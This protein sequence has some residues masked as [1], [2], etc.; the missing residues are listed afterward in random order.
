MLDAHAARARESVRGAN[1]GILYTFFVPFVKRENAMK[2]I[3][4][5]NGIIMRGM[6]ICCVA[7]TAASM[8]WICGLLCATSGGGV[9]PYW[10][11]LTDLG[12]RVACWVCGV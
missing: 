5:V 4:I 12:A 7:W 3:L 2:A 6:V 8:Y 1:M 10:G 11:G 9:L